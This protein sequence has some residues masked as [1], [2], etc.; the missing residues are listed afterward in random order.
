LVGD[1]GCD[2]FLSA[3]SGDQVPPLFGF[4][5]PRDAGKH[6]CRTFCLSSSFFFFTWSNV[7]ST[8]WVRRVFSP[9]FFY[10]LFFLFF[11]LPHGWSCWDVDTA[12]PSPFPVKIE[13]PFVE[14]HAPSRAKKKRSLARP[15]WVPFFFRREFKRSCG[16]LGSHLFFA[17]EG[18]TLSPLRLLQ[19]MTT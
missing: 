19:C 2:P 8:R 5:F 4:F 7:S 18:R 3:D 15:F 6:A 12:P 11:P 16:I 10:F 17:F 1:H 13:V 14:L 9:S